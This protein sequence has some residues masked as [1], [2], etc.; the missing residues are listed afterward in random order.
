MF[1][2]PFSL[3]L[4][5]LTT[6]LQ[7]LTTSSFKLSRS[8]VLFFNKL[9]YLVSLTTSSLSDDNSFTPVL[10]L[11]R[12]LLQGGKSK[13]NSLVTCSSSK[14]SNINDVMKPALLELV[15][16]CMLLYTSS[17]QTHMDKVV[18]LLIKIFVKLF[19]QICCLN[20]ENIKSLFKI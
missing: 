20:F 11:A 7:H 12:V 3:Y 2:N 15:D 9:F 13:D 5:N 19:S 1:Y 16:G 6:F 10:R 14:V 8:F 4:V 18:E 17:I